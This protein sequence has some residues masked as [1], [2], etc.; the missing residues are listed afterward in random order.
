MLNV[1]KKFIKLGLF[2][3]ALGLISFGQAL[4]SDKKASQSSLPGPLAVNNALADT[5]VGGSCEAGTDDG[6]VGS[7]GGSC[8]NDGSSSTF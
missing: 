6:C 3:V 8:G 1:S 4:F 2:V 7:G 5:P